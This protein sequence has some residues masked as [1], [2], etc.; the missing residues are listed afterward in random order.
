MAAQ[1]VQMESLLSKSDS[2]GHEYIGETTTWYLNLTLME[3]NFTQGA[4][5][6]WSLLPCPDVSLI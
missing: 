6:L 3:F 2:E 4:I 1:S 5:F